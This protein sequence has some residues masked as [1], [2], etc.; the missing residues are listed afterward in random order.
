MSWPG[1]ADVAQAKGRISRFADQRDRVILFLDNGRPCVNADPRIQLQLVFAAESLAQVFQLVEHAKAGPSGA[2]GGVFVCDRVAEAGQESLF[3]A[4]HH[5]P[6]QPAHGPLADLLEHLQY[7]GLVFGIQV[8]EVR[9]RLEQLRGADQNRHLATF[10][11]THAAAGRRQRHR[12]VPRGLSV[13]HPSGNSGR[14]LS[15]RR[16]WHPGVRRGLEDAPQV[17]GKIGCRRVAVLHFLGERLEANPLYFRRK[18]SGDLTGRLRL[19]VAHL[20][21]EF[22]RLL[23]AEGNA[24]AEHLVEDHAQAVNVCAAVNTMGSADDLL[25]RHI[26]RGAG[27]NAEFAAAGRRIVEREAEV[28]EHGGAAGRENDVGGFHVAVNRELGVGMSERIG[29]GGD[30]RHG[31]LPRGRVVFQPARQVLAVEIV[32]DDEDLTVLRADVVHRHDSRVTQP[33]KPPRLLQQ[34]VGLGGR[35]LSAAAKDLDRHGPI[36]LAVVTQ[37]DRTK[38]AVSQNLSHLIAAERG[39]RRR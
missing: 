32:G 36:E 8:F 29:H 9:L 10:G 37:I 6:V 39:R 11:F 1:A 31:V 20:P 26:S 13:G 3:V 25:G 15:Q 30:N 34:T 33:G 38:A 5:G 4:L 18:F 2:A 12:F 28:N 7:F 35:S 22:V 21:Q 19:V 16:G 14:R 17:V 27:N 24:T 23:R